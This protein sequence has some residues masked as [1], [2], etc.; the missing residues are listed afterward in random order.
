[1]DLIQSIQYLEGIATRAIPKVPMN[2][3]GHERIRHIVLEYLPQL[4]EED[5]QKIIQIT[6][7][8]LGSMLERKASDI[9]LGG[10]AGHFW[11]RRFDAKMP[12][13]DL[14]SISQSAMDLII[15]L[16]MTPGEREILL[17]NWCCDYAYQFE[18][19]NDLPYRFRAC[20]YF[21]MNRLSLNFR[22]INRRVFDFQSYQFPHQ[23]E[24]FFSLKQTKSGVVLITGITGSGKSTTLDA[25]I[26]LNNRNYNGHVVIIGRP[27]E[28][29]HESKGCLIRHREVGFDT[30]SFKYGVYEALRQ[31]PDI[32]VIAEM[33]D[34]DT[35]MAAMEAADSGHKVFST[36]HTSS[37]VDS[38]HRIVAEMPTEE[39]N[40]IRVRLVDTL[41]CVIS[42][43]LIRGRKEEVVFAKEIM[44]MTASVKAAIMNQNISEIYQMISEGDR[45]G[46]VTMEQDL[47]RLYRERKITSE[48]AMNYANNKKRM[49]QLLK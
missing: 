10:N 23:I 15:L 14:P 43:K 28:F 39:Q 4:S 26:D 34:T 21:E 35:M 20:A 8:I 30:R 6:Q 46:M 5:I 24:Q 22:A 9:E 18:V 25:I 37:A 33:R 36:M 17:K 3:S 48:Q 19:E 29:I 7:E 32:I 45:F 31:D 41:Q 40:R 16:T 27:I 38:I 2:L 47:Y 12:V 42:Q 1:M 13:S 49:H 44:V 11:I